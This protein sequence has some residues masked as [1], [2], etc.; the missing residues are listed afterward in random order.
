MKKLMFRAMNNDASLMRERLGCW[1][2][3][4][5]GVPAPRAVR[6]RLLINGKYQGM[7]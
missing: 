4:Q 2:F 5:M 6:A 3:R 7:F 1:L